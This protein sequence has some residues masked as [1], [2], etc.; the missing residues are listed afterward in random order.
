M[1]AHPALH[2]VQG[3]TSIMN[4]L[5]VSLMTSLRV[6]LM[7]PMDHSAAY[8]CPG[9]QLRGDGVVTPWH[10][11]HPLHSVCVVRENISSEKYLILPSILVYYNY[12]VY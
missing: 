10:S 7:A 11:A 6:I 2:C 5:M 4:S 8:L 9:G 1:A 3:T 12:L